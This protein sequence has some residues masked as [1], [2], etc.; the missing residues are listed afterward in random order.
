MTDTETDVRGIGRLEH[1]K[2]GNTHAKA[3][4]LQSELSVANPAI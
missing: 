3:A 2:M 4:F 1:K